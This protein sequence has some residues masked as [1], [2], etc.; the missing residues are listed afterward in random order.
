[1]IKTTPQSPP[2]PPSPPPKKKQNIMQCLNRVLSVNSLFE[3][4]ALSEDNRYYHKQYI[5]VRMCLRE[6]GSVE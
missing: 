6:L 5:T 2:S 3:K 4:Q 1:M